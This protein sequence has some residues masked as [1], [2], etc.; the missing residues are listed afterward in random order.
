MRPDAVRSG[1][2]LMPHEYIFTGYLLL[3]LVRLQC[4]AGAALGDKLTFAALIAAIAAAIGWHRRRPGSWALRARL[5]VFFIAMNVAFMRM[6]SAVP[7]IMPGKADAL[8]RRIDRLLLP[9]TPAMLLR[10]W[11][12]PWLTELLSACYQ[13]FFPLLIVAAVGYAWRAPAVARS[14]YSGLF[15]LYG[16]GFV[17]YTLAPALGPHLAFAGE[18]APLAGGPIAAWN[19]GLVRDFSTGVDV[20]PSLH[21]AITAYLL[22]IDRRF[23]PLRWRIMLLPCACLWFSTLYLRYHYLVDVLAG[24]ALAGFGYSMALL[25]ERLY[26]RQA[27]TVNARP[28]A[29]L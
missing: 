2:A 29:A 21:V 6:R 3:T 28:R 18:F 26:D 11:A 25:E 10:G 13:L 8:L 14:A 24:F 17:G 16:V 9:D 27:S 23:T 22:L 1:A 7:A 12:Q 20:F 15:S 19:A 4:A 5:L